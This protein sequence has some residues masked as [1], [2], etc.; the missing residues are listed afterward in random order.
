MRCPNCGNDV[1]SDEKECSN[2]GF[3]L[4][5]YRENFFTNSTRQTQTDNL[6]Q[7]KNKTK[8]VS[9]TNSTVNGMIQWIRVNAT[10]VF[11][12]G[13]LLL[14][15]MSFSIKL[16]WFSFFALMIILFVVCDKN[17]NAEQYTVDK[18]LTEKVN[19]TGSTIVNSFEMKQ[20]KINKKRKSHDKQPINEEVVK[21]VKE[22]RTA[23][24]LGVVLM[25]L[26][27][28]F[29]MFFGPLSSSSM[30]D[31]Q[32]ISI[33]KTLLNVGGL[34]GKYSLI[35]YGLWLVLL[36][37]PVA[38]IVLT[39]RNKKNNKKIVFILTFIE[40]VI[41]AILGFQLIFLNS[42]SNIGMTSTTAITNSKLQ[43]AIANAISF[44][45]SAYLLLISSVLTTVIAYKSLK[46]K[47]KKNGKD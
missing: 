38:I 27:S 3:N 16:G 44:G 9:S 24:Q 30:M 8:K 33:S 35:G 1:N 12:L 40:T 47:N 43:K 6:K 26:I 45:I 41:L 15:L 46:N 7:E 20:E 34:G 42:G 14:I 21:I 10:I 13:V 18:N 25:S 39:V 36:M 11:L 5:K 37:I 29:V 19:Q 32:E 22:K 28:L 4:E 31:F 2:C 23:T 17:P